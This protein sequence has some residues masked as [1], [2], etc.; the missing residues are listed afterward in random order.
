LTGQKINFGNFSLIPKKLPA[1][2]TKAT[3]GTIIQVVLQSKIPL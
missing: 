3:F 1:G 2:R